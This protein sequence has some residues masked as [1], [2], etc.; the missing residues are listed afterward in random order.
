MDN[1]TVK[2]LRDKKPLKLFDSETKYFHHLQLNKYADKICWQH[3]VS[4]NKKNWQE[5]NSYLSIKD[6]LSIRAKVITNN[7]NNINRAIK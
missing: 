2:A 4:T 7:A 5:W 1:L 6:V 3:F